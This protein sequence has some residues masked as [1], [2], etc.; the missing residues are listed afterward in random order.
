MKKFPIFIFLLTFIGCSPSYKS[1]LECILPDEYDFKIIS[2]EE[3]NLLYFEGI[4]KKG[5]IVH[6]QI[7]HFWDISS[8]YEIGD[9]IIK[10]KGDRD[11]KLVKKDTTIILRFWGQDGPLYP[12]EQDSIF[13]M[14]INNKK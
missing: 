3:S 8:F 7:Q 9:S 6:E 5:E 11:I 1:C 13:K 12:E 10:K 14:L 4:N 2:C